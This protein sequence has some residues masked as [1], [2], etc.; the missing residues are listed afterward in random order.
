MTVGTGVGVKNISRGDSELN[1]ND[2]VIVCNDRMT[3]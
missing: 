3:V 2:S 1:K